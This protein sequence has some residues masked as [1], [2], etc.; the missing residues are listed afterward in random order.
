M[1]E[2]ETNRTD[3]IQKEPAR[4]PAELDLSLDSQHQ[5]RN[6]AADAKTIDTSQLA[7]AD[8]IE[9]LRL[10]EE[11]FRET[12]ELAAV[13]IA[14]VAL[15]GRWLHVN[16]RFCDITGYSDTELRKM[17]FQQVTH[18]DDLEADLAKTEELVSGKIDNFTMEKRYLGKDGR[19]IWV[20]MTVSLVR[21]RLDAESYFISIVEDIQD[22]KRLEEQLIQALKLESVGKLAGGIAQEFNNM[23]TAIIGYSELALRRPAGDDSIKNDL[24]Q[25]L[26]AARHTSMLTGQLLAFASKTMI[27]LK[28]IDVDRLILENKRIFRQLA[29]ITIEILFR[30]H[31]NTGHARADEAQLTQAL[32]NLIVNAKDAMPSGGVLI[33]ATENLT[34]DRAET[35]HLA[36]VEA[37][38]YVLLTVT[39][40]GTG[41]DEQTRQR[42]FDPFFTTKGVGQGTG[43]G[44]AACY[45]YVKQIG[46]H[47]EVVSAPDQGT[48]FR[49]YLPR[50][51]AQQ[52]HALAVV[53]IPASS[54]T[55]LIVE[56]EQLVRDMLAVILNSEG[57]KVLEASNG[58]EALHLVEDYK[59]A[60]NLLISD[61]VMPGMSGQ[62][63]SLRIRQI[64]PTIEVILISG[65]TENQANLMEQ[66][67]FNNYSFISKPFSPKAILAKARLLLEIA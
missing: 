26:A 27:Q 2:Y 4:E 28:P 40:T 64:Y 22:R 55:I 51:A 38:D 23:M 47:I 66:I 19:P 54:K 59:G 62:E 67:P 29:G 41:M 1:S 35:T 32:I 9:A 5:H 44:L 10:S 52:D 45:G 63:L 43:L 49:L 53:N 61:V 21:A 58:E 34:V 7:G 56:D 17:Q 65:Y 39:D 16:R 24:E 12:F 50:V 18:P 31:P 37:G 25:V 60:I 15:D 8:A 46:G 6:V 20:N 42:I 36:E 48:T 57:Y 11:R 30:I 13:G 33:I 3:E 14:H